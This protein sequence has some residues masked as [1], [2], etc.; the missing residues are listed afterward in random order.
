M[1]EYIVR[2]VVASTDSVFGTKA[3]PRFGALIGLSDGATEALNLA[4]HHPDVFGAWGG[5][6]GQYRLE[7]RLRTG[8]A[9]GKEPGTSWPLARSGSSLEADRLGPGLRTLE[10]TFD[11]R[12]AGAE[13]EDDRTLHRKLGSLGV[14]HTHRELQGSHTWT[15][16][17]APAPLSPGPH[18]GD[19]VSGESGDSGQ[20]LTRPGPRPMLCAAPH[21]RGSSP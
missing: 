6:G 4:F 15:D 20:P 9:V 7:K 5:H 19:A 17:R 18:R 10:I 14:P 16:W 21:V 2:D 11:V 1:E 13:L 12:F 8:P 3:S